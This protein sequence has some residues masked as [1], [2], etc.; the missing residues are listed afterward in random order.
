MRIIKYLI[1]IA[2]V[3][4]LFTSENIAQNCKPKLIK[5]LREFAKKLEPNEVVSLAYSLE[6]ISKKGS[7]ISHDFEMEFS[8]TH[9]KLDS[10][11]FDML[12]DTVS[13]YSIIHDRKTIYQNKSI[14]Q[15]DSLYGPFGFY[16]ADSLLKTLVVESC[17]PSKSGLMKYECSSQHPNFTAIKLIYFLDNSNSI[18]EIR[19][20]N[21]GSRLYA[22]II[23]RLNHYEKTKLTKSKRPI[24]SEFGERMMSKY[25][26]YKVVN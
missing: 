2:T 7:S 4:L 23:M 26:K 20:K 18:K 8:S 17:E 22:E 15:P 16:T 11:Y 25:K 19:V 6:T 24:K 21:F 13:H 9:I 5:S 10:K 3:L 14:F 12:G 1:T